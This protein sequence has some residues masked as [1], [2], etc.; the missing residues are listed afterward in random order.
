MFLA[1]NREP[2]DASPMIIRTKS[3]TTRIHNSWRAEN[4]RVICGARRHHDCQACG[5]KSQSGK[6]SCGAPANNNAELAGIVR[7]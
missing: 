2:L 5:A 4:R 3:S 6:Q 1:K 7:L